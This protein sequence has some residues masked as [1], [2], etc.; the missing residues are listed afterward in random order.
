MKTEYEI[1]ILPTYSEDGSV[2][3]LIITR[4]GSPQP[5][6]KGELADTLEE[7]I[8]YLDYAAKDPN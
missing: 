1:S 2:I 7:F 6:T 4:L 3:N 5:I 8:R